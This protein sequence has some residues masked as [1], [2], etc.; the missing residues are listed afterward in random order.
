MIKAR[1]Y[2]SSMDNDFNPFDLSA[3]PKKLE[4]EKPAEPSIPKPTVK[5]VSMGPIFHSRITKTIAFIL[6]IALAGLL[7]YIGMNYYLTIQNTQTN[8]NMFL[9]NQVLAKS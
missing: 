6:G 4:Q 9:I 5:R 2:L 8:A 3:P 1:L 7:G